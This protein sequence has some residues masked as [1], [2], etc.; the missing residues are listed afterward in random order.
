M[1]SDRLYSIISKVQRWL[2]ALGVAYLA[3]AQVWN[4]PFGDQINQTIIIVATLLATTLEIATTVYVK[5]V[6][7]DESDS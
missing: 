1:M 7:K 4:L 2:P 3:L 6:R 5:K